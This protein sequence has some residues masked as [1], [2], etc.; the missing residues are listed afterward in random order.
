[1]VNVEDISFAGM[2]CR[3]QHLSGM[4]CSQYYPNIFTGSTLRLSSCRDGFQTLTCYS[5]L[6]RKTYTYEFNRTEICCCGA[7]KIL[8]K[9]VLKNPAGLLMK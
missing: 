8:L 4:P 5:V 7:H 2:L 9:K 3:S 1:M 6:L